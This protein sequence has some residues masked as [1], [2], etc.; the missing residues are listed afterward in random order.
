MSEI[1][2]CNWCQNED[3]FV[4]VQQ[5][6]CLHMKTVTIAEAKAQFY[7]LIEEAVSGKPFLISVAGNPVV[8]V[9]GVQCGR[10][11]STAQARLHGRADLGSR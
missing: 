11:Q 2:L 3:E 4:R 7:K 5:T 9:G 8:K 6:R 10:Q 1:S